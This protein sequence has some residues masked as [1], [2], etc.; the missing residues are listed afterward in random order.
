MS[1]DLFKV[2]WNVPNDQ[3]SEAFKTQQLQSKSS[4][5]R[6]DKKN[7][8]NKKNENKNTKNNLNSSSNSILHSIRISDYVLLN[9]LQNNNNNNKNNNNNNNNNNN[10]N[11]NNNNNF[12]NN[13]TIQLNSTHLSSSIFVSLLSGCAELKQ[14]ALIFCDSTAALISL[15]F[16]E[17]T[18]R[19]FPIEHITK[20]SLNHRNNLS[21]VGCEK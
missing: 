9:S 12:N 4:T 20:I 15:N 13:N 6:N 16:N 14:L 5:L 3:I 11:N 2:N 19:K 7:D 8:N 21:A 18:M 1:G 17:T 10:K